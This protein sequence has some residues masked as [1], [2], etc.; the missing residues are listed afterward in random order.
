MKK[1]AIA[2][3][4]LCIAAGAIAGP[5]AAVSAHPSAPAKQIVHGLK[6][7]ASHTKN[8][9][10][11]QKVVLKVSKAGAGASYY[12]LEAAG[13]PGSKTKIA[14]YQG[15]LSLPNASAKGT[16]TCAIKYVHFTAK[17]VGGGGKASCPPTKAEKK[18]GY[19]CLIS[20]ADA[21]SKGK[22]HSATVTF[23]TKG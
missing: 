3:A 6:I 8:V 23:S 1:I 20:V 22:K 19:S 2:G 12:C 7:K 10:P 15:T 21:A 18:K 17:L 9:K 16:F 5:V 13:I 4:G 11:G 14:A